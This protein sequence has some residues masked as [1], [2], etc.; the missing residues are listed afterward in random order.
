LEIQAV[1]WIY[2][3]KYIKRNKKKIVVGM[4]TEFL[5]NHPESISILIPTI[6]P[7]NPAIVFQFKSIPSLH[8]KEPNDYHPTNPK[9]DSTKDEKLINTYYFNYNRQISKEMSFQIFYEFPS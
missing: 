5:Y 8:S 1:C 7:S 2:P 6:T 3:S 4:K 9:P